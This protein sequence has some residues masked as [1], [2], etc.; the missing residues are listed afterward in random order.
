MN[1]ITK[2][3]IAIGLFAFITLLFVI[4]SC[5][6]DHSNGNDGNFT[7]TS[8]SILSLSVYKGAYN[9][10]VEINGKNFDTSAVNTKVLF[11]NKPAKIIA[12]S[13]TKFTVTVPLG[14]GTGKVSLLLNNGGIVSGPVFTYIYT[15]LVTTLANSS[16]P[17][18]A[19]GS[20]GQESWERPT[21]IAV[22]SKRNV[23]VSDFLGNMIYKV[24][25]TNKSIVLC[26]QATQGFYNGTFSQAMFNFPYGLA[27]DHNDNIYITD[28]GNGALRKIGTDNMVTTFGSA[29]GLFLAI[30]KN[31]TIYY[32]NAGGIFSLTQTGQ[33]TLFAGSGYRSGKTDGPRLD[34]NF[35][36]IYG[37][38]FDYAGNLFIADWSYNRISKIG[39]DGNVTLLAGS[40][41][42][43][44][45]NGKGAAASFKHP[46]G[47]TVDAQGNVYISEPGDEVIRKITPDGTVTT[48]AG[49]GA[50]GNIDGTLSQAMFSDPEGLAIDY[51][52]NI[53]VAD[54]GNNNSIRKIG[55]Q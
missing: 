7:L 50:D 26:G 18:G 2:N 41:N 29:D 30:D 37:M 23:Y 47:L 19:T 54:A 34:I 4:S 51:N 35:G 21:G 22:D 52:G 28:R 8:P 25:T 42:Y 27:V 12:A 40:G 46:T 49:T 1:L 6:K 5:K 44:F 10:Q 17:L 16:I 32:S 24:D 43:G 39:T 48:F 13:A 20:T 55:L 11:N 9:T 36:S 45:V 38:A 3:F 14:A 53:Y 31:N 15:M 33:N